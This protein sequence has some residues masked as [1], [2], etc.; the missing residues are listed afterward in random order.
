M[1]S[2]IIILGIFLCFSIFHLWIRANIKP[3]IKKNYENLYKK[4]EDA[5]DLDEW[6]FKFDQ[7][8]YPPSKDTRFTIDPL[9]FNNIDSSYLKIEKIAN[10]ILNYTEG[11]FGTPDFQLLKN[12]SP[13]EQLQLIQNGKSH[14]WCGLFSFYYSYFLDGV[15]ISSRYIYIEKPG[16]TIVGTHV[17]TEIY[18]PEEKKWIYSDLTYDIIYARNASGNLNLV[19]LVYAIKNNDKDLVFIKNNLNNGLVESSIK[20]MDK[21]YIYF[22]RSYVEIRYFTGQ[23]L[24]NNFIPFTK[25]KKITE[26]IFPSSSYYLFSNENNNKNHILF[27]GSR[28]LMILSFIV[29]VFSILNISNIR[30]SSRHNK[31]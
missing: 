28:V 23:Q 2:I 19:E 13:F 14:V 26:S 22:M 3:Y 7:Y 12:K 6:N 31:L 20:D 24:R 1:K 10:Y 27:V 17:I 16:D 25:S 11:R 8:N 5:S 30:F 21:D 9:G 15:G 29:L 4:G 18:I